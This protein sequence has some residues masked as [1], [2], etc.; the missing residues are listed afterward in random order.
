MLN[1]L[2]EGGI[3]GV[4][5]LVVFVITERLRIAFGKEMLID[6]LLAYLEDVYQRT[7]PNDHKEMDLQ[8][9]DLP[10]KVQLI[11]LYFHDIKS[12]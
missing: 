2:L 10:D 12:K 4:T 8:G 1:Y 5:L 3:L 7:A 11:K 9:C 6:K